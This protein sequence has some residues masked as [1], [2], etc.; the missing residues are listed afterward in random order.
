M[1]NLRAPGLINHA[2]HIEAERI[3]SNSMPGHPIPRRS[4]HLPLLSPMYRRKRATEPGRNPRLYLDK[5][6][7]ASL[8]ANLLH[9]EVDVPVATSK[10]PLNNTPPPL[11]KPE[12]GNPLAPLT[13]YLTRTCH[14]ART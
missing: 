4:S 7:Q 8:G 14:A 13:K 3:S 12:L 5:S 2:H 1:E 9:N 6:N 11:N 10:P